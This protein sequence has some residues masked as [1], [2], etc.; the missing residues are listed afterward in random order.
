MFNSTNAKTLKNDTHKTNDKIYEKHYTVN[1]KDLDIK[2]ENENVV[3]TQKNTIKSLLNITDENLNNIKKMIQNKNFEKDL[4]KMIKEG[5]TPLAI[6]V[7]EAEFEVTKDANGNDNLRPLTE[8]EVTN[9]NTIELRSIKGQTQYRDKLSLYTTV[10]GASPTYWVQSNAYWSSGMLTY[11]RDAIG[12]TW[13]NSFNANNTS[14]CSVSTE[15]VGTLNGSLEQINNNKGAAWSF[16][17]GMYYGGDEYASLKGVYAGISVSRSGTK[18][19]HFFSSEYVHTSE[20]M[21]WSAEISYDSNK[22]TKATLKLNP[23]PKLWKL[24]SYLSGTF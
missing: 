18:Q 13:D 3:V 7:A 8:N 20:K 2:I 9:S 6:G 24:V 5:H 15:A 21:H 17:C 22:L 19:R 4:K 10:S 14:K 12:V 23:S 1:L 11:H 16:P